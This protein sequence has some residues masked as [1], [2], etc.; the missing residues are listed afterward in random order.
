[1]NIISNAI[2][3]LLVFF[4]G[5]TGNL[6]LSIILLT[7][8]VRTAM[9]P[10][11]VP[12]Q[13][14]QLQNRDKLKKIKPEL[15]KLKE[16]HK[17]DRTALSQAQLELYKQHNI[18]LFSWSLLLPF[19]QLIFLFALYHVLIN[20]LQGSEAS[21]NSFFFGINLINK[22]ST[23]VLPVLAV[24]TQLILS[25]MI[26]PGVE[27]HDVVPND[28]SEKKIQELNKKE[29][30]E[31]EMAEQVSQQ[32]MFMLPVMT[33]IFALS[34]P[35]GVALYWVATTVFSIGQQYFVSGV[36]GLG[37]YWF[38]LLSLVKKFSGQISTP[39]AE[40]KRTKP[41]ES[42]E[43]SLAEALKKTAKNTSNKPKKVKKSGVKSPKKQLKS[44][45]K[46]K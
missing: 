19:V 16:K 36:G 5:L 1:M 29:T 7:V 9:I 42:S 14:K 41:S 13:K 24:I 15:A 40:P 37:K 28:S 6:G 3:Q 20:F 27:K 35:A 31:Q 22:D 21:A 39:V 34:F 18:Q 26:M 43:K 30:D 2:Y 10:L 33:G 44:S 32:M 25:V 8:A 11:I 4:Y 23:Y 12:S 45:K 46:R 38:K 17:N